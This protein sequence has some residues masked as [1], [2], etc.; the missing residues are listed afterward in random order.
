MGLFVWM[1][2]AA[3]LSAGAAGLRRVAGISVRDW[4]LPKITNSTAKSAFAVYFKV[5]EYIV[6][7]GTQFITTKGEILNAEKDN[8]TNSTN[9][10]NTTN[11]KD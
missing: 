6:D 5:G 1:F 4:V 7:T 11:K 2:D 8:T 9:T 10:T 3:V